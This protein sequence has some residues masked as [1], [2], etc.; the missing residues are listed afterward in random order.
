MGGG[1]QHISTPTHTPSSKSVSDTHAWQQI[2]WITA[3]PR[4]I[5][6]AERTL[7]PPTTSIDA[8]QGLNGSLELIITGRP[9][10]IG[11]T[12]G[13]NQG[14]A[15]AGVDLVIS[16]I[17][18]KQP[19]GEKQSGHRQKRLVRLTAAG[20]REAAMSGRNHFTI[21]RLFFRTLSLDLGKSH[22]F[23]SLFAV[24]YDNFPDH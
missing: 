21:H 15:G 4:K 12:A 16:V 10:L 8:C 3:T 9:K 1:P 24:T 20:V 19:A 14:D 2:E 23:R 6:R 7:P 17:E 22:H 13:G 11:P 5:T 18:R